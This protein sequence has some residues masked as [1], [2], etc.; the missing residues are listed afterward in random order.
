M[1]F[2]VTKDDFTIDED[3]WPQPSTIPLVSADPSIRR[4]ELSPLT[5]GGRVIHKEVLEELYAE[6]NARH[7]SN[8]QLPPVGAR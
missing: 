1:V 4:T 8:F 5:H 2:N 7:G 3:I 6:I